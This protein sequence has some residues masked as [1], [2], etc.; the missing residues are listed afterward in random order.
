MKKF[1]FSVLLL[2]FVFLTA[3]SFA[4]CGGKQDNP[5]ENPG[6]SL[7]FEHYIQF[8]TREHKNPANEDIGI[9]GLSTF[10]DYQVKIKMFQL[11]TSI[12]I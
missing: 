3:F 6:N 2:C 11:N 12:L 10:D 4:G 8:D 1:S 7:I 9:A 5:P